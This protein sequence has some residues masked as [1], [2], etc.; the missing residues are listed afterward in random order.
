MQRPLPLAGAAPD[1]GFARVAGV[2]HVHTTLSDGG[3]T[4]EEVVGAA[5]DAGL[6]FVAITDHN[7][8]DAKPIEGYHDGTLVLVGTEISTGAGHILGLGLAAPGF[9]F[10]G[11]AADALDDIRDLGGAAFAAHPR[12]PRTD[13]Q[14]SGTSLPGPWGIELLNGDSQWRDAGSAKLALT[15]SLYGVN[16]RYGLLQSLT[17]P[18]ATLAEWDRLLAGRDVPGIA[19]ADAHSRVAFGRRFALRFPSY[20]ALFGLVRNHVLLE[21]PPSRDASRD[22]RALVEAL[23]RG[24]SYVGVD[25]LADAS[26]FS[27]TAETASGS[28]T[29]GDTV[30]AGARLRAG[31]ALPAGTRLRL[32]RDGQLATEAI[33]ALDARAETPGVY[34]VE[35][36]VPG[37]ALP[38]IVGN[39]IYVFP[40]DA[41]RDRAR[42]AAWPEPGPAPPAAEMLEDFEHGSRFAPEFDPSSRMDGEVV[43]AGAGPD[44]SHAARLAFRLG[45]PGPGRPYTWC[46]LVDRQKRDLSGRGGLVFSLRGDGVYRLWLQ[47]RDA[48]PASADAGE[49][50]WFASVKTGTRWRRVAVPFARLR[51]I[52][53]ASDGRLDLDRLVGLVFLVDLGAARPGAA[54]TVWIDDLGV[55]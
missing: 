40:P 29:M 44:G 52:N 18:A 8:L 37:E 6:G 30:A 26:G 27:F 48:N 38:W 2:V 19:G 28:A 16:S 13:F 11:D 12:S 15:A 51:S 25:A 53:P 46:A 34:R 1:D 50:W 45:E 7:N 10:S 31:G 3:G 22:I 20:R 32:L 42:R 39:P 14:F 23:A 43:V 4:P 36:Y 5:R 49:E 9:R 47:V 17:P 54:G 55:Y 35:A 41:A 24:R 33:A 21:Q